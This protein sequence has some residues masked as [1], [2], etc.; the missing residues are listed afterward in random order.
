MTE[1]PAMELGDLTDAAERDLTGFLA[2]AFDRVSQHLPDH[3]A[4]VTTA[5]ARA[6]DP[7]RSRSRHSRD[8]AL[9]RGGHDHEQPDVCPR[10]GA[11]RGAERLPVENAAAR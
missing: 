2:V 9:R 1:L 5:L 7:P 6:L 11:V 3:R 10:V 4:P 8:G